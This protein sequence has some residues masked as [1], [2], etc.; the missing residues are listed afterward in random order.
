VSP[1]FT[2]LHDDAAED[3]ASDAATS[4]DCSS[5]SEP[6][7]A[8]NDCPDRDTNSATLQ[9]L[10]LEGS[11]RDYWLDD[12]CISKCLGASSWVMR[13]GG[14]EYGLS[15]GRSPGWRRSPSPSSCDSP[16]EYAT[17]KSKR[18][19]RDRSR[20][21]QHDDTSTDHSRSRSEEAESCRLQRDTSL[22]SISDEEGLGVQGCLPD[23][24]DHRARG[25]RKRGKGR[26]IVRC[27]STDEGSSRDDVSSERGRSV[28]RE[29][30]IAKWKSA[31]E[32][33]GI[34]RERM[35]WRSKVEVASA[36]IEAVKRKRRGEGGPD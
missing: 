34:E 12:D 4:A 25:S 21:R 10:V 6:S 7:G 9:I 14:A 23:R 5:H 2:P 16:Q 11:T 8:H 29:V 28:D 35:R 33:L 20:D 32:A 24:L 27:S 15:E 36:M 22:Q 31:E 1:Q 17:T 30:E 13:D 26:H 18:R 19:S 3:A